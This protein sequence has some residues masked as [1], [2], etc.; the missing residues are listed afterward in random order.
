MVPSHSRFYRE[1]LRSERWKA[2]RRVMLY[3]HFNERG[4]RCGCG[5]IA[6][7]QLHHKHYRTLGQER[8]S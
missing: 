8:P 4:A 6:P 1:H 2:F 7:L 5:R 3:R